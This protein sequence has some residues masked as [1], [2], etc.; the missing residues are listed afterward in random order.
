[1]S[2]GLFSN[3]D[4]EA[5][6]HI[7]PCQNSRITLITH[8]YGCK[9]LRRNLLATASSSSARTKVGYASTQ[10]SRIH[11]GLTFWRLFSV[12]NQDPIPHLSRKDHGRIGFTRAVFRP[13]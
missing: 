2:L 12:T 4:F 7:P 9:P 5:S 11:S 13:M 3:H 8:L 10:G 6:T 1:M